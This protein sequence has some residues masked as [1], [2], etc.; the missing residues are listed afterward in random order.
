V[1]GGEHRQRERQRGLTVTSLLP[2]NSYF[3]H[4]IFIYKF[5]LK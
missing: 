2:K 4:N 3:F 5:I 1:L